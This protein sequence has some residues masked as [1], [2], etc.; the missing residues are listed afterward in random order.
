MNTLLKVGHDIDWIQVKK[1]VEFYIDAN[2][3]DK[4]LVTSVHALAF[5]EIRNTGSKAFHTG[6]SRKIIMG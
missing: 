6:E 4:A 3:P 1:R 5:R 2:I